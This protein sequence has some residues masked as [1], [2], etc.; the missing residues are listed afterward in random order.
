M[1][2]AFADHKSA[3]RF[4]IGVTVSRIRDRRTKERTRQTLAR[5][6][7]APRQQRGLAFFSTRHETTRQA[8]TVWHA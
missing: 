7:F 2:V 1:E 5:S 4:N 3:V 6:Q 8:Y